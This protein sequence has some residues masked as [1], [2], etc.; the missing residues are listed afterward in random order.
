MPFVA[1]MN[2]VYQTLTRKAGTYQKFVRNYAVKSSVKI[3]W[4][5][6]EKP[7]PTRPEK[8]GDLKPQPNIDKNTLR[9]EFRNSIELETADD[10]VKRLFTL[11]FAPKRFTNEKY[12]QDLLSSVQMHQFDVK[13]MEV[14]IARWTGKI[15]LYIV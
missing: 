5:R 7:P 4:V 2:S 1:L 14:K 15:S 6:P 3:K 10:I 11:E 13:S 9:S 12:R 8:S